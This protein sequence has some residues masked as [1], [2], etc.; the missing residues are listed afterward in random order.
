M[1]IKNYIYKNNKYNILLYI[2]YKIIV[3]NK[4]FIL[5]LHFNINTNV[6]S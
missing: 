2:L 6:F 1:F 4:F 3:Y 5:I